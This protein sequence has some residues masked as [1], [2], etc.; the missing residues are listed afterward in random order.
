MHRT[1]IDARDRMTEPT[2]QLPDRHRSGLLRIE[3][4]LREHVGEGGSRQKMHF[5]HH[6]ANEALDVSAVVRRAHRTV[7][8]RD[9]VLFAAAAQRL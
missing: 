3:I 1:V 4:A 7:V 5:A 6:G 2:L 8:N 9:A